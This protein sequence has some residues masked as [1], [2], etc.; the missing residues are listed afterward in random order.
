MRPSPSKRSEAAPRGGGSKV[1]AHAPSSR[2]H[3]RTSPAPALD[4]RRAPSPENANAETAATC[5][6]CHARR[7]SVSRSTRTRAWAPGSDPRS[8][9]PVGSTPHAK[10]SGARGCSA[11]T[12]A[13]CAPHRGGAKEGV[14][15]PRAKPTRSTRSPASSTRT[16]SPSSSNSSST[17]GSDESAARPCARASPSRRSKTV[18]AR[19]LSSQAPPPEAETHT[20]RAPSGETHARSRARVLPRQSPSTWWSD[21]APDAR[22]G[23]LRRGRVIEGQRIQTP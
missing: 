2:D 11:S 13:R 1:H 17:T 18:Q 22:T 5:P 10:R 3:T 21:Q 19:T 23:S 20:A 15:T 4:A 9:R 8:Q 16:P 7:T 14:A 6:S 12:R